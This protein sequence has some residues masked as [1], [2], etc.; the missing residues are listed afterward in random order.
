MRSSS[1]WGQQNLAGVLVGAI[2]LVAGSAALGL[3]VNAISPRGIPLLPSAAEVEAA[4]VLPLPE[5]MT[6]ATVSQA[7][8]ALDGG[9]A[10]FIDARPPEDYEA[11]H[12]PGAVNLPA[13][14]FDDYFPEIVEQIEEAP[15]L[16]VYCD[17][18]EC[19]DSIHVAERLLEF[20]FSDISVFEAGYRAWTEAGGPTE[21]GMP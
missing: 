4:P 2:A 19:S 21:E 16:I 8:S 11:G 20:G 7:R 13:Y 1:R 12:L 5:G 14:E 3:F 17:G 18:A 15:R 9:T 6:A 10:L